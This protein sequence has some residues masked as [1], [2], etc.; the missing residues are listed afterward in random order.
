[1]DHMMDVMKQTNDE[2]NIA[3]E[4]EREPTYDFA[5]PTGV[6]AVKIGASLANGLNEMNK[7]MNKILLQNGIN[8]VFLNIGKA[9]S[10]ATY[11]PM[12]D[13]FDDFDE[14]DAKNDLSHEQ[15]KNAKKVNFAR[16]IAAQIDK[17]ID[18]VANADPFEQQY[19]MTHTPED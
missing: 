12:D 8:D 19:R 9:N 4:E 11:T 7:K 14:Y 5:Q 13:D 10:N 3:P 2:L 15:Q 17:V 16:N 1:M 6:P 18:G